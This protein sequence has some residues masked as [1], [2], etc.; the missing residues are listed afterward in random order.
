[1]ELISK[2]LK[3]S[4]LDEFDK[5]TVLKFIKD[6]LDFINNDLK[7]KTSIYNEINL[8][9]KDKIEFIKEHSKFLEFLN[10]VS[11]FDNI[12]KKKVSKE[13]FSL[14]GYNVNLLNEFCFLDINKLNKDTKSNDFV[15]YLKSNNKH[16]VLV[17]HNSDIKS[18]DFNIRKATSIL[19]KTIE[20]SYNLKELTII[21]FIP[22][23]NNFFFKMDLSSIDFI[24]LSYFSKNN[25]LFNVEKS[26]FK[27]IIRVLNKDFNEYNAFLNNS[28]DTKSELIFRSLVYNDLSIISDSFSNEENIESL[29]DIKN[30]N[31]SGKITTLPSLTVKGNLVNLDHSMFVKNFRQEELF[32]LSKMGLSNKDSKD[33]IIKEFFSANSY[34]KNVLWKII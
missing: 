19:F 10:S 7:E 30:F 22:F 25:I 28:K 17:L 21:N 5:D 31:I 18:K 8:S 15:I 27:S 20:S 33:L 34:I 23:I 32:Y 11:N 13:D 6:N 24:D 2:N 12:L 1:M 29:I 3:Y 9:K 4:D 14:S 26:N 16:P